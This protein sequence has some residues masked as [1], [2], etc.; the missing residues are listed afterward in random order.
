MINAE[1]EIV[2]KSG[3]DRNYI[4]SLLINP[5]ISNEQKLALKK[6]DAEC[7][8]TF[9]REWEQYGA[10]LISEY[11]FKEYAEQLLF[12]VYSV[13]EGLEGYIDVD[14]FARDLKY[15]YMGV[16]LFGIDFWG[17][18]QY[19]SDAIENSPEFRGG[20]AYTTFDSPFEVWYNDG[21][22]HFGHI[23]IDTN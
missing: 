21:V 5:D 2:G 6:F 3:L 14:A 13:P 19:N 8:N 22:F 12:D 20:Y 17:L 15:D 10:T 9:G 18:A 1:N 7:V 11:N 23:T 16:T 4:F